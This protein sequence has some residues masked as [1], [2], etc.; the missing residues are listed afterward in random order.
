MGTVGKPPPGTSLKIVDPETKLPCA[1]GKPGVLYA[2]GPGI[3]TGYMSNP[4]ATSE[5]IDSDQFFNTG[6]LARINPST[7]DFIITG[8]AKD[9]IVLSNGENIEPQSIEEAVLSSCPLVD[10]VMLVGQDEKFLA[11]L[12]VLNIPELVNTGII[13]VE[14]GAELSALVSSGSSSSAL[15][16]EAEKLWEIPALKEKIRSALTTIGAKLRPWERVGAVVVI[17]EPFSIQNGL[18]TQTMKIKRDKVTAAY[19]NEIVGIYN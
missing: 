12:T 4:T 14:K 9:T 13:T 19:K 5:A 17:L 15:R 2:K 10:Q 8:R 16:K 6:D 18:L 3:M 11:A 1:V 7:G